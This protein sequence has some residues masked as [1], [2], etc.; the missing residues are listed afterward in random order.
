MMNHWRYARLAAGLIVLLTGASI[1]AFAAEGLSDSVRLVGRFQ[2]TPDGIA[3][4]WPGSVIEIRFHGARLDADITAAGEYNL[5]VEVD[6]AARALKTTAGEHDYALVSG[7]TPSDHVVRLIRRTEA[8]FGPTVLKGVTTDGQIL[9]PAGDRRRLL[10]IGDSISAGYGV[11]GPGTGCG[12]EAR[13]ENQ[14]LA[15]GAVAARK[16]NADNI[17]LAISG[18][19][20]VRNYNGATTGTMGNLVH[21]LLPSSAEIAPLPPAD[22]VV[23]H[24]GTN[25]FA[26]GARPAGFVAAYEALLREVRDSSPNAMIYAAMGPMLR[27]D[28]QQAAVTA[29]EAS[30]AA[31]HD[32]GDAKVS[33][34][35]FGWRP[36]PADLGCDW[37]PSA[38]AQA[39]MADQLEERIMHDTG[40]EAPT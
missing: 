13:F 33:L 32:A 17:T 18:A 27:P 7:A 15:Y 24:L 36:D 31:R 9:P 11:E 14:Y 35:R 40:W 25:D 10:V 1:P 26:D 39:R 20:L 23:V 12:F 5:L 37:H 38:A 4:E 6:G 2:V 22:V 29:I 28:D 3:A 8:A 19:G 16:M 30:V 21:H 34:I